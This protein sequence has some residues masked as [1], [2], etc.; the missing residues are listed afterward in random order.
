ML[1]NQKKIVENGNAEL[2]RATVGQHTNPHWKD[3]R[4]NRLTASKFGVVA[5]ILPQTSCHN[6]VKNILSQKPL[7]N[8]AVNFGKN[9][10][11]NVVRMYLEKT[12]SKFNKCG[13]LL[14][15]IIHSLMLFQMAS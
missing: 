14:I 8:E 12:G 7:N 9:N 13:L 10:E 11:D 2:E 6:L 5:K 3:K 1:K 4:M 15:K